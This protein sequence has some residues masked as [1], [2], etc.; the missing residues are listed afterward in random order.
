MFLHMPCFLFIDFSFIPQ[1][2]VKHSRYFKHST[3]LVLVK[4]TN[5]DIY[6]LEYALD[7]KH[8]TKKHTFDVLIT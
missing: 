5:V 6:S 1:C 2:L 4:H 8:S 3:R 7:F